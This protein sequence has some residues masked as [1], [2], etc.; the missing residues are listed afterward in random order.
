MKNKFTFGMGDLHS[1]ITDNLKM[2]KSGETLEKLKNKKEKED[3]K[4]ADEDKLE[5]LTSLNTQAKNIEKNITKKTTLVLITIPLVIF[6]GVVF[7]KTY[8]M[9]QKDSIRMSAVEDNNTTK[10]GLAVD[11]TFQWRVLKD[12]EMKGLKK[13]VN[14]LK[15]SLQADMN[16][17]VTLVEEKLQKN[18]LS[19]TK[20]LQ[21]M[22]KDFSK[23]KD[24]I[25][26]RLNM[27]T[28]QQNMLQKKINSQKKDILEIVKK[29]KY[30]NTGAKNGINLPDL[31]PLKKDF[32][33]TS[34]KAKSAVLYSNQ[35]KEDDD[36]YEDAFVEVNSDTMDYE[37]QEFSESTKDINNTVAMPSFT[38][39]PGF[40]KG[41]L[42]NGGEMP[43]LTE[44]DDASEAV[45]IY[46]RI[47]G[48]ELIA[49]DASV[50]IDGCIILATAK[51]S[52]SKRAAELRLSKIS[53]NITDLD[54]S[55]YKIDQKIAGWVFDEN[56]NY[57]IKGR[58][59]SREKEII[60]A[61]LP[62]AIVESMIQS[63]SMAIGNS[64]TNVVIPVGDNP[65][66]VNSQYM[67]GGL[68]QGAGRGTSEV[69]KKFSDYYMKMLNSLNPTIS[70]RAGR[71]VTIAFKGGEKLQLSK[72]E[73]IDMEY[74]S[75][76]D[77]EDE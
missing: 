25:I 39:M 28:Q 68:I 34:S 11:T 65:A 33:H 72:Y 57:G 50:N 55:S 49:N 61:G 66:A 9:L 18:T 67:S 7:Y 2:K 51:G 38:L 4:N 64:N 47:N 30:V 60:K 48:D 37:T 29:T 21:S 52:L 77:I 6:F 36:I 62:L 31:P 73:P 43:I 10:M 3:K 75:E 71:K 13:D 27:T 41:L 40:T 20:E 53:C 54:G 24:E 74:F 63:L 26:N 1:Y 69:L 23:T 59:V 56:G 44:G 12:Q 19:I 58:L 42:I 14:E 70:I 76:K 15:T 17:T 8:K 32:T 22:K 16:K 45:P 46:I 5:N 35:K